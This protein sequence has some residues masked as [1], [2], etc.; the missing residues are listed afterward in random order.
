M[1][2]GRNPV[3]TKFIGSLIYKL[4]IIYILSCVFY[5]SF[6]LYF[7]KGVNDAEL[8]PSKIAN[9]KIPQMVIAFYEARLTWSNTNS[10]ALVI[11]GILATHQT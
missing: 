3:E 10:M 2:L 11:Y 7:R 6:Y 1:F 4:S 9:I 8:V 5:V